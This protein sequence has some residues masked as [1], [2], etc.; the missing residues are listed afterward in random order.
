MRHLSL[1]SLSVLLVACGPGDKPL[2]LSE[3]LGP[4]EVR[5]GVIR[6][7]SELIGGPTAQGKV[8]DFKLYNAKVAVVVQAPGPSHGYNGYGGGLI[9]ADVVRPAD[10]PGASLFGEMI[11]LYARR[12]L[13]GI[14]AEVINDG[15][16][17]NAAIVRVKATDDSFPI[18]EAVLGQNQGPLELDVTLDYIL[19]PDANHVRVV[20]TLRN[21]RDDTVRI[22]DHYAAFVLGNGLTPYMRGF[23]FDVPD[24]IPGGSYIAGGSQDVSYSF[25][26]T[27]DV[28]QPLLQ[29]QGLMV[30]NLSPFILLEG[31]EYTLE[32]FVIV[33]D[34]DMALHEKVHRQLLAE[35]GN[36]VEP[37]S[38]V[39]GRVLDA[40]EQPLKGARVH[41]FDGA[42]KHRLQTLARADG[43]FRM[44][45]EPGSWRLV[46]TSPGRDPGEATV[47]AVGD[48]G[49][50]DVVVRAGEVGEIELQVFEGTTAIPAKVQVRRLDP[51]PAPP[52][53]FGVAPW[54]AGL[55][56]VE[57][58][59]PGRHV[60][61]LP[62]GEYELQVSRGLEYTTRKVSTLVQPGEKSELAVELERVVDTT[63]W[64]GGDY[65]IHAQHSPDSNDLY[66]LK[67]RAFAGEGLE[68]P[69]STE[70]DHVGDFS[71]TIERL[72][73]SRWVRGLV[74]NE[75]STMN[76]GHFNAFPLQQLPEESNYGAPL[77]YG[78]P[79]GELMARIRTNPAKPLVQLNHPRQGSSSFPVRGYF[80]GVDFDPETFT[81]KNT[82]DW[83][84]DFDAIELGN[85]GAPR[86]INWDDWFAFLQRGKKVLGT[87]NSDSHHALRDN[88]GYPRN[89]VF[90]NTDDPREITVDGY[91][92]TLR[93]GKLSVSGGYF[94]E[95]GVGNARVGDLV[96]PTAALEGLLS[97]EVRVQAA[98]WV[99]AG[100]LEFVVNG[101]V[102]AVVDFGEAEGERPAVRLERTVDV[103]VPAGEDSWIVLRASGSGD[104]SPVYPGASTFGYTNPIYLDGNGNGR[105]DARIPLE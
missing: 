37:V 18:I 52:S 35:A 46:A 80:Q 99:P 79:A 82:F 14:S 2:D 75:V 5:A 98:P 76:I 97:V 59:L 4:G 48:K 61:A 17:G 57:F 77:W 91:M 26:Y 8:G 39:E 94:L 47:V 53:S 90:T 49:I 33:G 58:V 71:P 50:S 102:A 38:H 12:A 67:V 24:T 19:E 100:S 16:D 83:T 6:K 45:L 69:I 55:H 87:A 36:E 44:E 95:A 3:P 29:I 60:F 93:A 104:L 31:E 63:G 10:E 64:L 40:D 101:Q 88:I 23:G 11:T 22:S 27:E 20:T 84:L 72:G 56:Q 32:S 34:G 43:R 85:G 30:C 70:H 103:P 1:A 86:P 51:P 9:D 65:H 62:P 25:L 66:D 78:V 92:S 28:V 54:R 89:Y 96:P 73:L 74:G 42:G 13:R 68:I 15:R 105:F 7:E 21:T 81:A 41:V